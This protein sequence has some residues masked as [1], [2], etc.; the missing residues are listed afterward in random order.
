MGL[1]AFKN[2]LMLA[3]LITIDLYQGLLEQSDIAVT[4]IMLD[5][6]TTLINFD[7]VL[8]RALCRSRL[9]RAHNIGFF[10][11]LLLLTYYV[12]HLCGVL[13]EPTGLV[14]KFIEDLGLFLSC[15]IVF[16][17]NVFLLC[18]WFLLTKEEQPQPSIVNI[19]QERWLPAPLKAF[20]ETISAAHGSRAPP[21]SA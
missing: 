16:L 9:M 4:G 11:T 17:L 1:Y 6:K 19:I 15:L 2:L 3:R 14:V 20:Q 8:E 12:F 18:R 21:Y 5:N 7:M 10:T 13:H